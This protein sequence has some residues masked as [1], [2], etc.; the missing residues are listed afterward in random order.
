[1]LC[2]D[3]VGLQGDQFFCERRKLVCA[4]AVLRKAIID[5]HIASFDPSQVPDPLVERRELGLSL[6]IALGRV[7]EHP[8]A[9]WLLSPR[10][11]GPPGPHSPAEKRYELAPS[12]WPVS[13]SITSSA[14]TN[15][16]AG[17]SSPSA[18]AV[19]MFSTVSYLVG[20][21]TGRSD[22]FSPLIRR[23]MYVAACR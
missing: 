14:R 20:A 19:F 22:G 21:C 23:S 16:L 17:T 8:D 6:R 13:Y 5:V 4:A 11:E 12:H 18:L 2:E 1:P 3:H 10:H 15:T 7:Q 9:L